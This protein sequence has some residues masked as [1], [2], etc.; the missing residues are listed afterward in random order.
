MTTEPEEIGRDTMQAQEGYAYTC[1][2]RFEENMVLLDLTE[3]S[4][5]EFVIDCEVCC[6][7]MLI[8]IRGADTLNPDISVS[9][10]YD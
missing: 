9:R 10:A 1:P 5:Q 7:A 2:T 3:G 8:H 6:R 4:E